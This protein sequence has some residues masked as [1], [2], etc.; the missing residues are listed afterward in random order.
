MRGHVRKRGRSWSFVVDDGRDP[1]TNKRR[2]RWSSGYASRKEAEQALRQALGRLDVGDDPI[3]L[4]IT[5]A[6]H[7][8]KWFEHLEAQDKPRPRVRQGYERMIRA[9][10]LPTIGGLEVRKV[11]PAHCQVI[12]DKYRA[13]G[14]APRTIA[15][16]RAAMS[17]MFNAA[18]KWDLTPINP[19]RATSTPT[20]QRPKLT[21]PNAAQLT[22]LADAAVGTVWEIP[23]LIASTTGARRAE[24]LAARWTNVDLDRGLLRVVEA[25][26]RVDGELTFTQPKTERAV[27]EIPLTGRV[28]ERLRA[29]KVEQARRRLAAGTA[30]HDI[31]LVSERGDGAPL[32]PDAF[33]HGFARIAKTAGLKGVR[34]HDLRHGVATQLAKSG[35]HAYE[36]S[37]VLGHA[38]VHFTANTY[39]HADAESFERTRAALEEAFGSKGSAT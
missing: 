30:W 38:S 32:D 24:A 12:L 21:I 16:L 10:V 9:Q 36:T 14:R 7:A 28:V 39:Q 34:L 35:H 4:R 31:D 29:H 13:E 20:P 15:K 2:Q 33:T 37:R 27:R 11:K 3:P 19:C 22:G 6:E 18:V 25:L 26:Q 23:V 17:S 1:E 5:V 8:E